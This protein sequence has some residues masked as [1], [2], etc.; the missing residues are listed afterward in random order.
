M[1]NIIFGI[2]WGCTLIGGNGENKDTPG[3]KNA[4][5]AVEEFNI[6][7]VQLG[8]QKTDD[9]RQYFNNKVCDII[10]KDQH[11]EY[12]RLYD[13]EGDVILLDFSTGWCGPCKAA[14]ATVQ[15]TQDKYEEYGFK[16]ITILIEDDQANP[17]SLNFAKQWADSYNIE[18]APVLR[19]SRELIDYDGLEGYNLTG[20]PTFYIIDRDMN[21]IAG[22]RGYS[23]EWI[24]YQVENQL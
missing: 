11:D 15:E 1:F 6:E 5:S 7:D 16:Y 18:T 20:W 3:V 8:I 4:D 24:T 10:L 22:I 13:Q 2:F 17:T 19:G 23:E 12:Y 14:A 9:C 21:L